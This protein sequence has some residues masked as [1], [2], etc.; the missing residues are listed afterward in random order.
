MGTGRWPRVGV[1]ERPG[2]ARGMCRTCASRWPP[3]RTPMQNSP[4]RASG[5]RRPRRRTP[6]RDR[7]SGGRTRIRA[8]SRSASV[9]SSRRSRSLIVPHSSSTTVSRVTPTPR[10]SA[11]VIAQAIAER[12]ATEP[13]MPTRIVLSIPA[14][15]LTS[16]VP[17]DPEV[18]HG[19]CSPDGSAERAIGPTNW[20]VR[21]RW[22]V[23][24][25][26]QA[27]PEVLCPVSRRRD[28]SR[29]SPGSSWIAPSTSSWIAPVR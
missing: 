1:R 5:L 21:G 23:V 9:R 16:A 2:R 20:A 19:T 25:C 26:G 27:V 10:A 28:P 22:P 13:S 4:A 7:R 15:L 3:T 8:A 12:L 29:A 6:A 14:A 11:R 17:V 24:A 18:R